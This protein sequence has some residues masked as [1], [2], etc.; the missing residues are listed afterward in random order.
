MS[1]WLDDPIPSH[2]KGESIVIAP[3]QTA[4]GESISPVNAL[5]NQPQSR[6]SVRGL[7]GSMGTPEERNYNV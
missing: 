1:W 3:T 4:S 7:F 2:I 5:W 6:K